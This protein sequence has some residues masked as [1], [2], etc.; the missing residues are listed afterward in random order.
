VLDSSSSFRARASSATLAIFVSFA[1]AASYATE[2]C[3]NSD[4]APNPDAGEGGFTAVV[5]SGGGTASPGATSIPFTGSSSGSSG[6][7]G[8]GSSSGGASGGLDAGTDADASAATDAASDA[9]PYVAPTCDGV[10][11]C[12]LRT[13]TCCLANGPSASMP[14]VGTCVAGGTTGCA[15]NQATVHCLQSADCTGSLS[16]CGEILVLLGQVEAYCHDLSTQPL[17]PF[18]ASPTFSQIGVQLCKTDA[19]C[20]NGQPCVHQVCSYGADVHLC[21]LQQQGD[22]GLLNCTAL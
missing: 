17:C 18:A 2:G 6:A 1:V 19:E 11:P 12:D 7:S 9:P 21:G 16:C 14:L 8:S 13:N 5:T 4:S 22:G 10:N 15:N 20:R 3:G